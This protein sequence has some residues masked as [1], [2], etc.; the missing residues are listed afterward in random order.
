MVSKLIEKYKGKAK[1]LYTTEDPSKFY[2]EFRNDTSAF[3]GIKVESLDRKGLVNNY[4]NAHIMH[5]LENNGV[6]THFVE[7]I[8]DNASLVKKLEM[9]PLECVVRNVAAGS[10][11]KRLGLEKGQ[12]LSPPV[13]EFFYKNDALGDPFINE[14]YIETF[15]WATKSD[16]EKMKAVTLQVNDILSKLF[17]DH[18]MVLVDYKLEFG[19][20]DGKIVLGDEFTPDGCRIWDAETLEVFDKDRFRQDL[21]NVVESYE[22]VARRLSVILP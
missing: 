17:L 2:C 19:I 3:N 5:H 21:G 8:A 4:F 7:R 9:F 12:K 1:T 16:V 20:T 18:G 14:S 22:T 15:H 6:D 13:F 11:C 10:I